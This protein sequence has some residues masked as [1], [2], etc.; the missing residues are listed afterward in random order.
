[1]V[2]ILRDLQKMQESLL[3]PAEAPLENIHSDEYRYSKS[4]DARM[5]FSLLLS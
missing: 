2:D 3:P 1:M 5:L 4:Y